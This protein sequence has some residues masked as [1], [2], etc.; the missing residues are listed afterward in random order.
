MKGIRIHTTYRDGGNWKDHYTE[1]FQ[2][3][4]GISGEELSKLIDETV[5]F[6]NPVMVQ[7]YGIQSNAPLDNEFEYAH[8]DDHAYREINEVEVVDLAKVVYNTLNRIFT[9]VVH[10]KSGVSQELIKKRKKQALKRLNGNLNHIITQLGSGFTVK[11]NENLE[12]GIYR[13]SD[14]KFFASV[15]DDSKKS[16]RLAEKISMALNWVIM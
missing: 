9:V 6:D 16:E 3:D 2:N 8:G 12:Y 5:G 1:D 15:K 11:K 14:G 4:I 7:D 10:L 13:I